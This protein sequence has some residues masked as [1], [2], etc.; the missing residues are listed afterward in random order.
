MNITLNAKRMKSIS[1]LSL[2]MGFIG[3]G[4]A[5]TSL[6]TPKVSRYAFPKEGVFLGEPDRPYEVLG[7][8]RSQATWPT[9]LLP[10]SNED[11]L[12]RNHYN[13]AVADLLKRARAA[14]GDAVASIKSIVFLATGKREEYTTPECSDDGESGEILLEGVA[15][16]FKRPEPSPSPKP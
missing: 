14:G 1:G 6:P 9:L 7:I 2:V 4:F 11:A 3:I 10:D 16:R 12:C 13:K 5:C 8:V 15:V